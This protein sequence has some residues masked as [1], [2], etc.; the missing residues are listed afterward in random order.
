MQKFAIFKK[1]N[2]FYWTKNR[3]IYTILI[4]YI[5]M[6]FINQKLLHIES[7]IVEMIFGISGIIMVFI[8]LILTLIGIARPDSLKGYL[9]GYIIFKPEEIEVGEESIPISGIK[10]IEISNDDYYGKIKIRSKGDF[11]SPVSNGVN[12]C[13][14]ITLLSNEQKKYHYQLLNAEDFQRVREELIH[15]YKYGKMTFEN[16]CNVLGEES[17]KEI[18]EFRIEVSR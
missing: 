6:I 10:S 12:N 13:V 4:S 11:N 9:E 1:T 2:T 8:F 15:Y 7:N 5:I 14:T 18:E 17:E 16:V 3:A